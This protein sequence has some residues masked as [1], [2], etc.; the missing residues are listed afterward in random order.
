MR[1]AAIIAM[2]YDAAER[3]ALADELTDAFL[4]GPWT[5]DLVAESGA[6]CL[7][8]WPNWM[9]VLAMQVVAVH[10]TPPDS[11]RGL[12][13]LIVTFLEEHRAPPGESDPPRIL[14]LTVGRSPGLPAPPPL[15]THEWAITNIMSVGELAER[16]EL[17]HGQLAWLA[18]IRSLRTPVVVVG[19]LW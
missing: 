13:D 4:S 7:E 19:S 1:G 12:F 9:T 2:V 16:L 17:S 11:R 8:R 14:R 18:D 10:R 15:V 3:A 5:V 6:A